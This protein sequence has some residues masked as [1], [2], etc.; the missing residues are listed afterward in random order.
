MAYTEA[1]RAAVKAAILALATGER[2]VTVTA[3]DGRSTTWA[4]SD[5]DKLR[6][7][8][9]EIEADISSSSGRRRHVYTTTSKGL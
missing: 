3:A 7:L 8:L 6:V 5:L 4:Q 2:V 1:D 9:S